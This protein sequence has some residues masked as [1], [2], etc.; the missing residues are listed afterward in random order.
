MTTHFQLVP[1]LRR[2]EA[3]PPL[4]FYKFMT[5]IV[6]T[7]PLPFKISG[8]FLCAISVRLCN[9]RDIGVSLICHIV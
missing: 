7:A 5:C 8:Q 6:I 3:I 9:N 4:P 2:G 1:R